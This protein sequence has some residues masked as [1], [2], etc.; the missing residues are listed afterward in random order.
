MK[1]IEEIPDFECEWVKHK[2]ILKSTHPKNNTTRE[3][4]EFE[5]VFTLFAPPSSNTTS[6]EA[7]SGSLPTSIDFN[8]LTYN[9][10]QR[11]K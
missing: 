9:W 3:I 2:Y 7:C 1:T 5:Q 11:K 8:S 4:V 10:Y 6:V